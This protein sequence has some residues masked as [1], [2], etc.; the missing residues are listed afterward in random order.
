MAQNIVLSN[1]LTPAETVT[2][3]TEIATAHVIVDTLI[4]SLTASQ[5]KGLLTVSTEKEATIKDIVLMADSY[6]ELMPTGVS[7]AQLAAMRQEALDCQKLGAA[8]GVLSGILLQ[9]GKILRNDVMF[10]CTEILDNGK[11]AGKSNTGIND[12]V[13]EIKS[14]HYKKSAKKAASSFS[15]NAASLIELSKVITGR[16][17]VNT[18]HTILSFLVKNGNVVDTFTVNPASS[19]KIPKGWTN[20]V[21]T[22]LSATEAG[23]FAVFVK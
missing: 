22:N 19:F 21:V 10:I 13:K 16:A 4:T 8:Y 20:I 7:V 15:I 3:T 6:N 9:R 23:S 2:L 11:L 18:G 17:C 12:K 14:T 1:P 5:E